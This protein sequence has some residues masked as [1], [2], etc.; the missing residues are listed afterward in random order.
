MSNRLNY[1]KSA[2]EFK[3]DAYETPKEVLKMLIPYIKDYNI[4]YDPFYCQGR[5]KKDWEELGKSCINEKLDAFTRDT[6]E[7]D[8]A[9]SNIPFS[10]KEKCME[11]FFKLNKPFIILM[12]IDTMSSVWINKY[13]DKL[14]F[15]IP[16][17]RLNFSKNGIVAGSCWFDTC[18]YCYGINLAKI[19]IKL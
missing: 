10:C 19:I 7:F 6:P 12:P 9:I 3:D 18:F 14:Q 17:K 16:R 15:I 4:I 11:L 2:V 5:V 8:I 13:F 1:K